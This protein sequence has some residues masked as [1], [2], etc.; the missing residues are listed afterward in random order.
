MATLRLQQAERKPGRR[1]QRN[2]QRKNHRKR[3]ANRHRTHIR[4]HQTRHKHHRQ[5]RRN[6]RKGRQNRRIPHLIDRRNSRLQF[7]LTLHGK[8]TMD[9]LRNNNR[10]INHNTRHKNQRK[11]RHPVQRIIQQIIDQQR[12][13]KRDR[14]RSQHHQRPPPPKEKPHHNRHRHNRHQQMLQ[15]RKHLLRGR[16][17]IVPRLRHRNILRNNRLAQTR[18]PLHHPVRQH[19]S[20][21]PLALR[22]RQRHRRILTRHRTLRSSRRPSEKVVIIDLFRSVNHTG[23]ITQIDRRRPINTHNNITHISRTLQKL[24]RTNHNLLLHRLQLTRSHLTVRHLHLPRNLQRTHIELLQLL[25]V[26]HNP[27]L[28]FQTTLNLD[29]TDI[30]DLLQLISHR[31]RCLPDLKRILALAPEGQVKHRHIINRH[32]LHQREL[33]TLRHLVHMLHQGRPELH[34]TLLRILTHLITHRHQS[35]IRHRGRI[36]IIHTRNFSQRPLNRLGHPSLNLR[37][38]RT[39]ERNKQINHRHNNLRLLLPRCHKRRHNPHQQGSHHQQR[40]NLRIDK[41]F[42]KFTGNTFIHSFSISPVADGLFLMV[43]P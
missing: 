32:L 23:H 16:R 17:P 9:V 38:Q 12:Q 14:H 7:R 24:P 37:R 35:H 10:I 20:I 33:H 19:R 26:K 11:Q 6:N 30:P 4:P 43:I 18:N 39:R 13:G 31:H 36:D 8:M 29:I 3:S 28:P 34:H 27:H 41:L 42:R 1:N 2:Q 5:H 15:Q 25:P 40:R 22:H 21:A